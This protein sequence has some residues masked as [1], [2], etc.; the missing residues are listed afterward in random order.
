MLESL[1]LTGFGVVEEATL[2][3]GPGL[4]ALTGETGAGKT[5]IVA[6]LGQLLGA[7]GDAGVVRHG[8][9]KAVVEGRWL[10]PP[11]VA[12]RVRDLGGDIDGDELVT[13]RQVSAQGRSRAVLGGAGV[14]VT[15]LADVIGEIAT[16]HG[17]SEQIRLSSPERQREV[18][19]AYAQPAELER[20]RA[21]FTERRAAAAEL[22]RLEDESMARARE[23]DMLRFGLSEIEGVDPQPGED[24]ALAAE[25]ARLVDLD[26]L[27]ALAA[28]AQEAMS[29]A[30]D[31]FDAPSAVALIGESRKA[32][33]QLAGRDEAA[34]QLA[35]R[36]VELGM[37]AADLAG[38]VAG[39]VADL[40]ADPLRLEA[41]GQRRSQLACL[42]RKYGHS[43]DEVL[44][45][46]R[47]SAARLVELVG[48]DERIGELRRRVEELDEQLAADA[49][50]ISARRR[51]AAATL[52]E[53]VTR[54]LSA[55]AMPHAR[56]RFDISD[57]DLG[58]HGADRIELL[59]SAN[60]GSTPA[61]LGRVASGG[62]LSRVRLALEV[63][64]ADAEEGHTFV[65]DEVDAGVGGAVG[66][67]IGRRLQRLATRSQV[68]VVTHLAQVAAFADAHFV[69][70]KSSTGQV[71]TSDVA[72]LS[73][74]ERPAELARMMSGSSGSTAGLDHAVELLGSAARQSE[75]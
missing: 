39:Y 8:Q 44:Q 1:R 52:E 15:A 49:A 73:A 35:D 28:A 55:L 58:P 2:E 59:F 27:R 66:L 51:E 47:E 75:K 60:P 23:A 25:Q 7:R 62:E 70:A 9:P 43:V 32:L 12:D 30:E 11:P 38:D 24:E 56:L 18:L 41:V 31:N 63:V 6:G 21:A 50:M 54:E 57:A 26:D 72:L 17:Q 40:V 74:E 61:P 3:L 19:D 29:G 13:L 69:V 33:A 16:I 48:S 20:Y 68:I 42:T 64:L 67:E 14:P 53:Q 45:W 4:T 65:F 22:A 5:M 71:T 36:A 10:V 46:A 37:L 34:Q